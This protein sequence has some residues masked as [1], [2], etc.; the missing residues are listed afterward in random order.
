MS[1]RN[2]PRL[3][4]EQFGHLTLR[5]HDLDP[6]YD[7]L[8]AM[9]WSEEQRD[10][11]LLAYWLCYH[12]GAACWLSEFNGPHYW[13]VLNKAAHN[14]T[15]TPVGGRWPRAAERRHWRGTAAINSVHY[16][17]ERYE[18]A[19]DMVM[20]CAGGEDGWSNPEPFK[21]V[22]KRVKEHFAFGSWIAYKVADMLERCCG[23]PVKF[24]QADAM[25]ESPREA[26]IKVWL[27]KAQLPA[28]S[29]P[30]NEV[31]AVTDVIGYLL[32]TFKGHPAPGGRGRYFGYQ[33]AETV[34]CKWNSHM[35]GH[36]PLNNDL[37]EIRAGFDPWC[38]V[39]E[40]AREFAKVFPRPHGDDNQG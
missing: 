23:V 22:E 19:S 4:I 5:A 1:A 36:Y 25:Y 39:S 30:K 17:R 6:V 2:Y 18:T 7:A 3:T 31:Q 38:Q 13:E 14:T 16:L 34:L 28:N 12:P 33:E 9:E 26:A 11:W 15:E 8:N 20:Y 27:S 32:E 29:R 37:V 21:V 24:E 10:R 40:T 35:S